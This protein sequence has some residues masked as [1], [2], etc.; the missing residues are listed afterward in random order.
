MKT[1]KQKMGEKEEE[2]AKSWDIVFMEGYLKKL[3]KKVTGS[4]KYL[5]IDQTKMLTHAFI[6]SQFKYCNVIWMF[7]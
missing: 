3:S 4:G 7:C 2:E 1:S 6:Y 5:T